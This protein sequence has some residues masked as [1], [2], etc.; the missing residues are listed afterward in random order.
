MEVIWAFLL[1]K[2]MAKQ[3]PQYTLFSAICE[4]FELDI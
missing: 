3:L 1:S 4:P 2:P